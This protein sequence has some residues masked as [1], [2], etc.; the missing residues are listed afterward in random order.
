M[1]V[2][3]YNRKSVY[4]DHSDSVSNQERMCREHAALRYGDSMESFTAYQDEGFS[5]ANTD[6]PGLKRLMADVDAGKVDV[7][8]VYQLDRISR[9]V[10]DFAD[11][12][13]RLEKKKVA[14]VSIKENIDTETPMGRAMIYISMVFAQ[15]ERETIAERVTD[16]ARGLA[17]KGFWLGGVIP[18]GYK[19][20]VIETGGKKHHVLAIDPDGAEFVRM[21]YRD[22]L[23]KKKASR[24]LSVLYA[25]NGV[26]SLN[27]NR[28]NQSQVQ[29]ILQKA[30]YCQAT[31]EVYDWLSSHGYTITGPGR[32]AWDGKRGVMVY[33]RTCQKR[34]GHMP[35][36]PREKWIV[37]LG[38]HEPIISADDWIAVQ[39][40]ISANIWAKDGG[41]PPTLLKGVVRCAYCGRLMSVKR[42]E[43]A[44]SGKVDIY[45][46]CQ[47]RVSVGA[48]TCQMR[49][50]KAEKLDSAL[51]ER[52]REAVL[53]P[54][55]ME[56]FYTSKRDTE[57]ARDAIRTIDKKLDAIGRKLQNLSSALAEAGESSARRYIIDE[58]GMLDAEQCRLQE[59]KAGL[60]TEMEEAEAQDATMEE[61]KLTVENLVSHYEE[62][63]AWTKNEVMREL[64]KECTWDGET[65]YMK[66]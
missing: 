47:S 53:D 35:L 30:V 36:A 27:G 26:K 32:E 17:M 55:M 58:L 54:A 11:I 20:S 48:D 7:I 66:M 14:F 44:K 5:G 39:E 63:D 15:M 6:R 37:C 38:M 65:L 46:A 9:N 4:S 56:S 2:A 61:D 45:Y 33:G 60:K 10:K 28:I 21:I 51:M 16:N 64:I 31:G 8:I 42:T 12:W 41:K 22:F 50:I 18:V 49:Y 52:L 40:R 29:R 19:D 1:R 57:K 25:K 13:D 43:R 59:E 62:M 3:T 23:T 34:P 24:A